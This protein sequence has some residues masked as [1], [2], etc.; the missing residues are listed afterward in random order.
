MVELWRATEKGMSRDW[1]RRFM[2]HLESH[3]DACAQEAVN[4]RIGHVPDPSTYAP[5]RRRACGPFLYDLIEPVLGV[6]LPARLLR[7]PRW[8]ALAHAVADA[9]REVQRPRL[10]RSRRRARRRPLPARGAGGGGGDDA[11]AVRPGGGRARRRADRGRPRGRAAAAGHARPAGAD[12]RA[13]RG[14]GPGRPDPAG[15]A[16]RSDDWLAESGRYEAGAPVPAP[17]LDALAS[18]R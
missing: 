17:R 16:A 8:K 12:R 10:A 7:T 6:E 18:L 15:H 9:V 3:R 2:L 5:L 11:R 13:A 1:R 14:G 4:R